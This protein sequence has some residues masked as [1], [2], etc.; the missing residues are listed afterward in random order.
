MSNSCTE[1]LR[2]LIAAAAGC[3][4]FVIHAICAGLRDVRRSARFAPR[5]I[6]TTRKP[7]EW[8]QLESPQQ[9]VGS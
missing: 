1:E 6:S 3:N 9:P 4:R 2:A 8:C 7:S 5:V